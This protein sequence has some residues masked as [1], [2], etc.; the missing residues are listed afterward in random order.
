[1][2]NK[3]YQNNRYLGNV[4]QYVADTIDDVKSIKLQAGMMGSEVYVINTKK[5]YI[6]DSK[7]VWHSKAINSSTS[8]DGDDDVIICDCVEE[9]TIWDTLPEPTDIG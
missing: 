1:M 4:A 9:S 6:L 2:V 7:Y 3:I 8:D 5:T